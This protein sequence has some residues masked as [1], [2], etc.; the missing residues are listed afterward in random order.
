MG[1]HNKP[2][3]SSAASPFTRSLTMTD[4]RPAQPIKLRGTPLSGHAHRVE[5]FLSLLNL[6]Y[7][8]LPVDLAQ[9]TQKQPAFLALNRFGQ[10]PVIEDG[11]VLL[12]DSHAI[13]V[14]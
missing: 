9:G 5:L 1:R 11:D 3:E 6:P 13:L 10:V 12:A 2:I 14:Y 4:P 7:E 8:Y